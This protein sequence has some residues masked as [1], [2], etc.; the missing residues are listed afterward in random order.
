[1]YSSFSTKN[2][3]LKTTNPKPKMHTVKSTSKL[4]HKLSKVPSIANKENTN[5]LNNPQLISNDD[6]SL[7]IL[8][9]VNPFERNGNVSAIQQI[10][11]SKAS[12]FC[13][14]FIPDN[15]QEIKISTIKHNDIPRHKFISL[16]NQGTDGSHT[17]R[18]D[19]NFQQINKKRPEVAPLKH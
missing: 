2:I 5:I 11:F 3:T 15:K 12:S 1:M 9:P 18:S 4:A 13:S 19:R 6:K 17:S 8:S 7:E 14:N 16:E 10:N